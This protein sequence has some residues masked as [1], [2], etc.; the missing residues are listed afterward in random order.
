[1]K[2]NNVIFFF[3]SL[4]FAFSVFMLSKKIELEK[5]LKTIETAVDFS[6]IRQLAG[7][8]GKSINEI[9]S[10]I[11]DVGVTTIGIEESTIRELSDRGLIILAD[12]REVDKWKYIFNRAPSFLESRQIVNKSEYTYVF[13]ENPS[14]GMMIKNALLLKLPK[15]SVI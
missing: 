4:G 5:T 7:I 9:M 12:G 3:L 15:V 6:D 13:T 1:M 8:S 11:K 2:K 10:D 14:L